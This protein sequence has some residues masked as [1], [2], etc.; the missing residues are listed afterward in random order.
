M[1]E[2]MAGLE[3]MVVAGRTAAVVLVAAVAAVVAVALPVAASVSSA[4]RQVRLDVNESI[5]ARE[6]EKLMVWLICSR[7]CAM[8][9]SSLSN[10]R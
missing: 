8:L 7:Q 6:S 3:E 4:A 9:E 1:Q 5:Y 10:F 2:G